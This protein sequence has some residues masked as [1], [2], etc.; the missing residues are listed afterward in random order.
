MALSL[1]MFKALR[2]TRVMRSLQDARVSPRGL[3]FLARTPIVNAVDSEIM[4][5]FT[6]GVLIADLVADGQ[7][8][9]VYSADK[10][11][12]T[13]T[14]IPNLK[15]GRN[16]TQEII[17]QLTALQGANGGVTD[18]DGVL[19]WTTRYLA[20]V[21]AGVE[22]RM[23]A[24]LIAMAIDGFTY[25][26][27]GI[28]MDG[29]TW[30]MPAD[31]KITVAQGWADNPVLATPVADLW[32]AR[33][34][35]QTR[36]GKVYNRVT[37]STPA[38]QAMIATNEFQA[39]ARTFLAP[40]VSDVNLSL[41]DLTA[42]Q[43]IANNITGLS[44]ELYDGRYQSQDASGRIMSEP[45]LPLDRII[46][47]NSADDNDPAIADFANGIVTE[48][49]VA[50]YVGNTAVIGG[51]DGPAYGPIAYATAN[52]TLN[53]PDMT[54][55]GVARG[56]PRKHQLEATATLNIG[57]ITNSIPVIAPY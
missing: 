48:S 36:Y 55:W 35:A 22:Q 32:A 53:P 46:L 15:I 12:F 21:L 14:T 47:A 38:F 24:L 16:V 18:T 19:D 45:G 30:G 28:R 29:V 40:N 37:M 33:L 43:I 7:A 6:G 17:N 10:M 50:S 23:E 13:S 56:F 27:L 4:A 42:Q 26:R 31:L 51:M 44:V 11:S 1:D 5:R 25:E 41:T 3:P 52:P 39:K 20:F 2:L 54:W 57:P 8:A 34:V 9:L 49:V